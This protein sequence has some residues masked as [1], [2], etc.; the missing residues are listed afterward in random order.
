[1]TSTATKD[2]TL[3]DHDWCT[4]HRGYKLGCAQYE[5]LLARSGQE[6]EICGLPG[7]ECPRG[8]LH[9]DH[10][11]HKWAVRGLLCNTCNTALSGR[12]A[13]RRPRWAADYLANSWWI[14]ECERVGVPAK[15]APEP[16]FGSVIRDQWNAVWLR[17]GDGLWRPQG[18]QR[19]G[20]SSA[21]WDWLYLQ[22][23]PHN[24][25]P[26]NLYDPAEDGR[27]QY[28]E[29]LLWSAERATLHALL[30]ECTGKQVPLYKTRAY[31]RLLS[32]FTG[33]ITSA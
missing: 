15:M 25:A 21:T 32:A 13:E 10:H 22:R 5:Y 7:T 6:C 30:T 16:D 12:V 29:H 17:E 31:R 33:D 1:M 19:P 24:L 2:R 14:K 27:E 3:P 11:G 8:K 20:I 26:L 23:G 28:W 4:I 18:N 9:I